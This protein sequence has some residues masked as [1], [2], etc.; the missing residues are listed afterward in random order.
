MPPGFHFPAL[1][2][3]VVDAA[4]I[5]PDKAERAL[6][7]RLAGV[8]A[9]SKHQFFVVTV[10]SIGEH[11]IVEY[12]VELGRYWGIGRSGV[13]DGVLLLVAP[14]Q[15]QVRIEVGDGLEDAL[16]DEEAGAIIRRD[17]LPRFKNRDLVG[18][19]VAG[20]DSI[21]REIT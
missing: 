19:I 10:R 12:G 3:R 1:T 20:S 16:R 17:I 7:V 6:A 2:G 8:E 5:L 14:N 4:D 15:R 21:I 9:R 11:S 13:D 18:G